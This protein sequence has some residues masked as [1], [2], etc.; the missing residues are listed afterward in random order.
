V[1]ENDT[2]STDDVAA[3]YDV[4]ARKAERDLDRSASPWGTSHFQQYYSWPATRA[5][6]PDPADRDVL[7]AGCGRGDY[8]GWF[9]D[10]GASVTGVDVSET[11]IEHAR[12][13]FGDAATFHHADL[14]DPLSFLDDGVFDLVV[15][16]LVFSHIES[17]R[18]V[19]SELHRVTV[20]GGDLVVTTV[21]PA[22]VRAGAEV[23][24]YYATVEVLNDWPE[25]EIPT[26]YRPMSAV[27]TPFAEAGYSLE[28]FAEPRPRPGYEDHHPERYRDALDRPELLVVRARAG[29]GPP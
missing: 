19:L 24:D 23:D 6:L 3:G 7:L 28:T 27:V 15:S 29:E 20:P 5:V 22:Y 21:H 10:R 2:T 17:W 14:T 12:E 11:A 1:D 25:V 13:R 16:N 8:V 18:P 26:Y 9:R 4:L